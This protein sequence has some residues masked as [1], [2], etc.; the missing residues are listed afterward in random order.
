MFYHHCLKIKD[1]VIRNILQ[2]TKLATINIAGSVKHLGEELAT[3]GLHH[4]Q[5]S[6]FFTTAP[7][8]NRDTVTSESDNL[9]EMTDFTNPYFTYMHGS[10][11]YLILTQTHFQ[12]FW[13]F[14]RVLSKTELRYILDW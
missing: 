5:V 9:F 13:F 4:H 12:P 11:V 1:K 6:R 2:T 7:T 14:K 10:M 8:N 3:F